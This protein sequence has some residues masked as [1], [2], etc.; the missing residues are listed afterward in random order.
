LTAQLIENIDSC[1][2]KADIG[3]WRLLL[4]KLTPEPHFV[5]RKSLL[6]YGK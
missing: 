5:D 3:G 1:N 6:L 2:N 4:R